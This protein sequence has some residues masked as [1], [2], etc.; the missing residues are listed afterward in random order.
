MVPARDVR[1]TLQHLTYV[2]VLQKKVNETYMAMRSL[3]ERFKLRT[4]AMAG[5]RGYVNRRFRRDLE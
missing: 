5:L 1:L 3:Y 2:S 4:F